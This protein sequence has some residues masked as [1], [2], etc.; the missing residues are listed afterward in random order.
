MQVDYFILD[1]S[2]SPSKEII[3]RLH[4]NIIEKV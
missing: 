2:E 3:W 4:N 1:T